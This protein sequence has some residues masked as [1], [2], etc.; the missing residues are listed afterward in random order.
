MCGSLE[1]T[2][3]QGNKYLLVL[4]CPPWVKLF[5]QLADPY[6]VVDKGLP[7]LCRE[8]EESVQWELSVLW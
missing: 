4:L 2:S 5:T 8:Q 6:E 3:P 7:G 1:M